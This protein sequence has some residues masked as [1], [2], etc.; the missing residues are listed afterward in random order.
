MYRSESDENTRKKIIEHYHETYYKM[1]KLN[2][3][4]IALDPDAEL[5]DSLM[6]KEYVD[7]WL[8]KK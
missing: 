3:G 1:V 5:P 6:P 4:I 2:K 8:T 7:F